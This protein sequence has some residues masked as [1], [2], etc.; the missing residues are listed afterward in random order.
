MSCAMN[1]PHLIRDK[2]FDFA[3]HIVEL[4]QGLQ[5]VKKEYILSKQ[6]LKSGTSIGA[7]IHESEHAQSK[8]DFISKMS[9]AL[10]EAAETQYWLKLLSKTGY[11]NSLEFENSYNKCTE[12]TA[13]LAGAIKTLRKPK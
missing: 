9:I 13:N 6:L 3:V 8:P 11:L 1:K 2:S 10:K 5:H 7:N 12:I 4:V